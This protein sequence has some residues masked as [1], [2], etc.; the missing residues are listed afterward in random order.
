MVC[1]AWGAIIWGAI[2]EAED[3]LLDR[4]TASLTHL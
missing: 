4:G 1:T 3:S 2:R